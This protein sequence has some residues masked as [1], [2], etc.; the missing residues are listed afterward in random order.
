MLINNKDDYIKTKD[1]ILHMSDLHLVSKYYPFDNYPN[2][3]DLFNELKC[4]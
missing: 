1:V 2:A 3:V 4:N